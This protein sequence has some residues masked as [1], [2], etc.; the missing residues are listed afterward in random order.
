MGGFSGEACEMPQLRD[1]PCP[2]RCS[3]NGVCSNGI[4]L[5]HLGFAGRSCSDVL[6]STVP[7]LDNCSGHGVCDGI[8]GECI[9]DPGFEGSSCAH[10][11]ACP[12]AGCGRNGVCGY[13]Q[14]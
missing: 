10:A 9:C 4:C 8:T 7:C 12:A 13:G 3:G 6:D 14:C 5:C 1:A 2:R 11:T